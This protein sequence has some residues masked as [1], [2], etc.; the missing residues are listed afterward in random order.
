MTTGEL[1]AKVM[2]HYGSPHYLFM[3]LTHNKLTLPLTIQA[4]QRLVFPSR[5]VTA[6]LSEAKSKRQNM[7]IAPV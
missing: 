3:V 5:A 4:G 6:K 2:N 1:K 7:G